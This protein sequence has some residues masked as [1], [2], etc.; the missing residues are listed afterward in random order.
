MISEAEMYDVIERTW[1]FR[2]IE[3][4]QSRFAVLPKFVN[5]CDKSLSVG[6]GP[7]EPTISGVNH[8]C[9]ILPLSEKYLRRLGWMGSYFVCPIQSLIFHPKQ[10]RTVI[11]T[12]VLEHLETEEE[13]AKAIHD[14]DEIST[15]WLITVP[16]NPRGPKNPEKT[17]KHD[18]DVDKINRL[19]S[20]LKIYIS[21][22]DLF[23]YVSNESI[24]ALPETSLEHVQR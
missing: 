4:K 24:E 15:R 13:V 21:K 7:F 12:E 14:I 17:H 8:G 20:P 23:F 9:D 18:F 1:K 22:D 5:H 11:C 10:F 2:G 19:S 16:C 6:C 3:M